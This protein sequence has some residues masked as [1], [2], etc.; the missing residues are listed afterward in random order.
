MRLHHELLAMRPS[1]RW[2]RLVVIV[3]A[4][5]GGILGM[6]MIGSMSVGPMIPPNIVS[7]GATPGVMVQSTSATPYDGFT[8]GT[9]DGVSAPN[10][11]EYGMLCGCSS[12][13][14][15]ASMD[16]HQGC[17]PL[18][19]STVGSIPLPGTLAHLAL[20]AIYRA[21]PGYKSA[22]RSPDPPSLTQLSINRT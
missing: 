11:T 20:G 15:P 18:I 6:H 2:S 12:A 9:T 13:D 3:L 10:A 8:Y 22:D 14:C 1:L 7:A 21:A 5:V 16:M 17:V 4:L 19:G